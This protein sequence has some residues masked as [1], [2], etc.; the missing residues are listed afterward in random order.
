MADAFYLPGFI[1]M[2]SFLTFKTDIFWGMISISIFTNQMYKQGQY[3]P[4][5]EI[6]TT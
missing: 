3:T 2:L 1:F 5:K 6:K 4:E